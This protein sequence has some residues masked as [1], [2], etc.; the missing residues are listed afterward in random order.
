LH[1]IVSSQCSGPGRSSLL[2]QNLLSRE[3]VIS[4]KND[5][6]EFR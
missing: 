6:E 1:E 3:A 5:S 4:K 2:F